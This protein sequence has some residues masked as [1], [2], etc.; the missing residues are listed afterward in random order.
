LRARKTFFQRIASSQN[1]A[2]TGAGLV[3]LREIDFPRHIVS[4]E[5][6]S[7]IRANLKK[8]IMHHPS[9]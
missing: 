3:D 1:F 9:E 5:E 8:F 2:Q 6:G 4:E 7:F